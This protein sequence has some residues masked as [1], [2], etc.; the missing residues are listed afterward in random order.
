MSHM[1]DNGT[2]HPT[3]PRGAFANATAAET[4]ES[5]ARPGTADRFAVAAAGDHQLPPV[6]EQAL[7]ARP[8]V[9]RFTESEE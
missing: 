5:N 7:D 9:Q 1:P 6:A 2:E 4:G 3:D 8:L